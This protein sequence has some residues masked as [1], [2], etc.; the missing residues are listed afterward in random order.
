MVI[1]YIVFE[2]LLYL[3]QTFCVPVVTWQSICFRKFCGRWFLKCVG[4][5]EGWNSAQWFVK[6]EEWWDSVPL[7]FSRV[8]F[9]PEYSFFLLRWQ[10]GKKKNSNVPAGLFFQHAGHRYD[11]V[12]GKAPWTNRDL[13]S[14]KGTSRIWDKISASVDHYSIWVAICPQT[15]FTALTWWRVVYLKLIS[16]PFCSVASLL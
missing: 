6:A 13:Q 3:I 12:G 1:S 16:S 15:F 14:L 9:S 5:W 10:V 4:S 2:C 11:A 7:L 8:L